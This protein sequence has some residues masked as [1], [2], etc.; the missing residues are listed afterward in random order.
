MKHKMVPGYQRLVQEM[1]FLEKAKEGSEE[2]PVN[3]K[4]KKEE[5][6]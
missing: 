5:K 4:K 6:Y 1:E 3:A 2:R